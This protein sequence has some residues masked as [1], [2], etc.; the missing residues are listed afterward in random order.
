MKIEIFTQ[1]YNEELLLPYF[2][3]HYQEQLK[4]CDITFNIYDNGST[5]STVAIA[6]HFGA[7]VIPFETDGV[8]IDLMMELKNNCWKGS[9]ADW[10]IL[11][12]ADEFIMITKE[13]LQASRID[14]IFRCY[15]YEM[16]ADTLDIDKVLYG[17][18]TGDGFDRT[19]I[20]KPDK[21]KEVNFGMGAHT[22]APVGKPCVVW[23]TH[24]PLLFHI[25]YFNK[26]YMKKRYKE[27]ALRL[28][29]I[30]NR[31]G[32]SYHYKFSEKTIDKIFEDLNKKKQ[33]VRL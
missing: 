13:Q 5:D 16:I 9:S 21:I 4:D 17:V 24:R 18:R 28:T 15:A 1:T 31:N 22:S 23:S 7:N 6:K 26:D 25:K 2:F 32:W 11:P 29:D 27:L 12:D 19:C 33:L 20:F 8:R 30:D 10:V 14:N 3:R